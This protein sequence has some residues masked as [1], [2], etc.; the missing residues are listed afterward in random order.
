MSINDYTKVDKEKEAGILK[1]LDKGL[2]KSVQKLETA[3]KR[4]QLQPQNV[5]RIA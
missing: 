5:Q 1:K 2:S 3:Q 4:Q